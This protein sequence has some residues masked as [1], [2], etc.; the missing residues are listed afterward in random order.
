MWT[1]S[2]LH[3]CHQRR[4]EI[5]LVKICY[6]WILIAAPL[7]AFRNVITSNFQLH[8][9]F[10]SGW[11][12]IS[13][14][15]FFFVSH[16]QSVINLFRL[17]PENLIFLKSSSSFTERWEMLDLDGV[18]IYHG[19]DHEHRTLE[20]NT[21]PETWRHRRI[22]VSTRLATLLPQNLLVAL[23]PLHEARLYTTHWEVQTL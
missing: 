15:S 5:A 1:K 17:V 6:L 19:T 13:L 8:P 4:G 2:F 23:R 22:S 21:L 3:D 18:L 11:I 10:G 9:V 14:Y 20:G 16:G 7:F 12:L